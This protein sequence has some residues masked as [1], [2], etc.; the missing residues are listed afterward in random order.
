MKK[1][2]FLS[3]PY[4]LWM[5]LFA[6]LPIVV[7]MVL[8]F[9]TTDG[10]SFKDAVFTLENFQKVFA[11]TNLQAF[12]NSMIVATLSTA[13]CFLLGYPVAYFIYKSNIKNRLLVMAVL[14][15]PMWSN[16]LLRTV[17]ISNLFQ[18]Q[19]ILASILIKIGI[20]FSIPISGTMTAVI[21]GMISTYIPFM[22]LPIYTVLEKIDKS[23]IEASNDLGAGRFKTFFKV[24]FPMSLKGVTT[25]V[26]MV[27]LPAA[28]GFAIPKILSNDT[29]LLVGS[30][31]ERGF[32]IYDYNSS[33]L[34][35]ILVLVVIMGAL[36]IIS[37]IDKE[38]ETLL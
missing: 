21:I 15:L 23:L 22:I 38:G 16:T 11:Q 24:V 7:M 28:T 35:S 17:A 18:E 4:L 6:G 36:M 31:I 1:F 14:I 29:I 3:K 37:K 33:S 9:F 2:S 26:I 27:F 32:K 8:S 25:G 12:K 30:I 19:N 34:L 10:V 13:G 5:I 20:D